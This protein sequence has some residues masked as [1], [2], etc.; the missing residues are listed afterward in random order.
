LNINNSIKRRADRGAELTPHPPPSPAHRSIGTKCA[1]S[2]RAGVARRAAPVPSIRR[3]THS[4]T[5][6][7]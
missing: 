4:P 7:N 6:I 5:P 2:A 1:I 3:A